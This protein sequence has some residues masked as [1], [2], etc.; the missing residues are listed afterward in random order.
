MIAKL[1][2]LGGFQI[3]Y[4][5]SCADL[6]WEENFAAIL[7]DKGLNLTYSIVIDENGFA[8]TKIDVTFMKDGVR[9]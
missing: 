8:D 6:R 3:F 9:K 5:L 2:N 1:E 4:T 7:R